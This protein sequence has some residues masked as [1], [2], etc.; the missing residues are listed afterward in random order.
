MSAV[1]RE[2]VT[3]TPRSFAPG[4]IVHAAGLAKYFDV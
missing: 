3:E 1:L 4:V 2:G